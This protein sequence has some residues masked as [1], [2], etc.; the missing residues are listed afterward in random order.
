M[1]N[2]V[3]CESTLKKFELNGAVKDLLKLEG[4][5]ENETAFV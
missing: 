2:T 5:G 4:G 3:S 1:I